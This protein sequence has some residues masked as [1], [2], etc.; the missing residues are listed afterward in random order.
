MKPGFFMGFKFSL[1]ACLITSCLAGARAGVMDQWTTNQIATNSF[2]PE[3]VVFGNGIY[4][5]SA[6]YMDGIGL[7]TSTDGLHWVQQFS[8]L[9]SWGLM[10]NYSDGEFSGV[11]GFGIVDTSDDG[12]N[13]TSSWLP[14]F[15]WV[16]PWPIA[17]AAGDGLYV[18]VGGTNGVGYI[19]MSPDNRQ[20]TLYEPQPSMGGPIASVAFGAGTFVAVGNDDGLVYVSSDAFERYEWNRHDIPG[21]NLVSYANGLFFVPLNSQTNL[22]SLDGVAWSVQP[23]GLTNI[24]GTVNYQ[25][26]IFM[27]QCF[28]MNGSYLATSVDGTNWIQYPQL[29]PGSAWGAAG[30]VR[31]ASDGT[32]LVVVGIELGGSGLNGLIYTSAPLVDVR[33]ATNSSHSLVLS[34]LVGRN[35]QIQ[36]TD[37]LPA[38]AGHWHTNVVFQLTSMQW[39]WTDTNTLDAACFYRGVLLP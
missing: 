13:W 24:L 38:V 17:I 19:Q 8:D 2:L 34:G 28:S 5:A 9:N 12:T 33:L 23:T 36:S 22:L 3:R 18:A 26:G 1:Y 14:V 6:E 35:Y 31:M 21:G 30:D 37:V 27:A 39:D 15:D 16:Q 11:G 25:N 32:R 20:W 10:L 4:V 7:Y 29:L